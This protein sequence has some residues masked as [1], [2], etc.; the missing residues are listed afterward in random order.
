VL[1]RLGKQVDVANGVNDE[2][3]LGVAEFAALDPD[4]ATLDEFTGNGVVTLG[5]RA[6]VL[7]L[8]V[9]IES[10]VESVKSESVPKL[11]VESVAFEIV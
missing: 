2:L 4:G 8:I 1:A 3:E 11:V 5:F 7:V 10:D 6:P 9:P